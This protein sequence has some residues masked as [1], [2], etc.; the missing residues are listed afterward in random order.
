MR[1]DASYYI[2]SSPCNLGNPGLKGS[3]LY[4]LQVLAPSLPTEIDALAQLP[5]NTNLMG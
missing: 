4:K 2:R 1:F 3:G 5:K